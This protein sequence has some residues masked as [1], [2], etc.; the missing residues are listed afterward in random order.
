MVDHPHG[1]NLRGA[2]YQ[3]KL[4][5]I[6][7]NL[8]KT[9]PPREFK[10]GLAEVLKY[11]IIKDSALFKLLEKNPKANSQFWLDIVSRCAKIKAEVVSKDEKETKGLRLILNLGHTFAHA[12]ESITGYEKF[13]HG[14]AV[15]LG[16]LASSHL[17]KSL[18]ILKS[19]DL[20]RISG[21]VQNLKLP[22][23]IDLKSELIIKTLYMDKKVKSG[24][25]RFVLPVN[26]GKVI[27]KDNVSPKNV[28]AALKEI[29]CK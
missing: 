14:E 13:T 4:V 28:K 26:I 12:I 25:I 18:G 21:L 16:I 5:Y 15:A 3:P 27:V 19:E 20:K 29:G 6:D 2:F 22:Q 8:L 23:K 17:S 24:K 10:T 1:K 7:I 9:L 11:G